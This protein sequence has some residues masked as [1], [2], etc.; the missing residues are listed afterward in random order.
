MRLRAIWKRKQLD[1]D[2]REEMAFH[3]AMRQEKLKSAG[4]SDRK[5]DAAAQR[6]FGN[7]ARIKE[8]T[9]ML[10]TFRWVEDLRQDLG[11]AARSLRKSPVLAMVVVF[12]LAL[13]IGAN[14]AIFSLIN[15][16]ML[17]LLPIDKPDEL[18]LVQ[19]HRGQ[20]EGSDSFT[21]P[22]WESIRDRQDVFSGMFAWSST[23][24]DLARGG[25]VQYVRGM[26]VSGSYFEAL[27]VK[28]ASGR[29]LAP[30]DDQ[31]GCAATAVLSYGFWQSRFGAAQSAVG[32]S[33][34]LN[35]QL[36]QIIGVASPGFSGVEVGNKF[37]VAVPVCSSVLFDEKHPRLDARSSWWLN[38]IGR[39]KPGLNLD[40]VNARLDAMS[41]AM[42]SAALPQDWSTQDQQ[43]FMKMRL[44]ALPAARG[45]SYLRRTFRQPLN[46][47]MAIVAI[48]LLIACANI[49][50]LMLA[51]ATARS[52]EIAVR[53][54][55]GASRGRLVR[56]LLTESI[57]LSSI[58]A[59]VGLLFARWGSALM[60]RNLST[61]KAPVFL[62][63]ALDTRVLGFTAVVAILTGI[64]VGFLPA[65][66]STSV[67]LIAA[68]KGTLTPEEERGSRFY[69]GKWIV[70]S[71][72]ALSLVL[73]IGVGVLVGTFV[74]LL[75]QDMGFDPGNVLL[76]SADL[77]VAGVPA[78][79]RPAMYE[80]IAARL[81][82]LPQ[83]DS[84]SRSWTTPLSRRS[85]NNFI[86][87]DSPNAPTGEE[88]VAFFNYVSP[89]YFQTMRTPLIGGRSFT[90]RDTKNSAPVAIVT[91]TL[92][93][94]FFSGIDPVGRS[95]QIEEDPGKPRP[96]I[97]IVGV[98]KDSKYESLSEETYPIAFFPILQ[99]QDDANRN[100][101][102]EIRATG[103][104]AAIVA[105]A[106]QAIGAI[107]KEIPLEFQSF[108]DQVDDS[109]VQ[110]RLLVTL[111]SFFC[112]LALLLAMI[113][114][115]G[116]ISYVVTQR[117][118]EF[119]IRMA[120]GAEPISILR[121]VMKDVLVV[122]LGGVAV[123][124]SV[125]LVI[126]SLLSKMF[127]GLPP[128]DAVTIMVAVGILSAM[129]ILAG[130]VPARRAAR[131]NPMAALRYE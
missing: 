80:E 79:Q 4:L 55:L 83:I 19:R 25:P 56:Q 114:L 86:H 24:F 113:G 119:G 73:L 54:A 96:R 127:F 49:A 15:A 122:L 29:L 6:A 59:M 18:V 45:T 98:V 26:F 94:K 60:V 72:L 85:W 30:A 117:W 65:L 128:H 91:E 106:Q 46:A 64:L 32:S 89:A 2:L 111:S 120:L 57:V 62:D 77:D 9:R 74:K 3:L 68:M 51:R 99:I 82:E 108:S 1:R 121:L 8:D 47:L 88:A 48:V 44:A 81:Q 97:E 52:K 112:M 41:P 130:A 67:S 39:I 14:T 92:A 93:R 102:F 70:G 36:F 10:W 5:A 104:R 95:F 58:G 7:V 126:T 90:P 66:R 34:S 23:R 124:V 103:A 11:Y 28:P 76:V 118:T 21:N 40:E 22:L 17:R 35:H 75:H 43:N 115:Y 63:L 125:S 110:Q 33:V 71:Q 61:G 20:S 116:V 84:V 50:S 101:V 27:G 87:G 105:A 38:V 131:I 42:L 53:K 13:G 69:L 12:S 100:C 129:A 31:R 16:V 37:D 123:G 109:I 107:N 78:E